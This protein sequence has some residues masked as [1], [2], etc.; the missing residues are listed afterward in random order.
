MKLKIC[1]RSKQK[2]M[3]HAKG[4]QTM[5][6]ENVNELIGKF[7]RWKVNGLSTFFRFIY[8]IQL[9]CDSI[10]PEVFSEQLLRTHLMFTYSNNQ[11]RRSFDIVFPDSCRFCVVI[12][13]THTHTDTHTHVLWYFKPTKC[14]LIQH[15]FTLFWLIHNF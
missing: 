4:Q 3:Y 11:K 14:G 7:N 1:K 15:I 13:Y 9:I 6:C 5:D 12:E 10:S 2:L 8:N